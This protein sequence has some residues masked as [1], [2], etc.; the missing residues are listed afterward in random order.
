[1]VTLDNHRQPTFGASGNDHGDAATA[2]STPKPCHLSKRAISLPENLRGV[3][4]ATRSL[5]WFIPVRP[6][7]RSRSTVNIAKAPNNNETQLPHQAPD[8]VGQLWATMFSKSLEKRH[9]VNDTSGIS[10]EGVEEDLL[11]LEFLE[12]ASQSD[13]QVLQERK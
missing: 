11:G 6:N 8:E 1:M 10:E 3:E 12:S 2:V 9:S 7:K 5:F 4:K 13:T